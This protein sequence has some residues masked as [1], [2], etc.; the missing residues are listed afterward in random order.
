PE[1]DL[2]VVNG[3]AVDFDYAIAS[4]ADIELYPVGTTSTDFKEKR[5]QVSIDRA[6]VADGHLG[7]LTRNLRLLGFD[8]AYDPRAEDPQLLRVMERENRAL[9]TRDRRLLMHAMVKTGYFPR[10][11]N[12]DQQTIEVIRRFDLLRAIAPFTRCL[13]CN[14]PLQEVAKDD[15][16]EKLEPLTKIYYERFRRCTGCGH[17]YWAGSHFSK[18]QKRLDEIRSKCSTRAA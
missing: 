16:I 5:L 14:A 12:A 4:D 3:Q 15:V 8:V 9:L 13:R 2:I 7:R 11:Q 17:I 6:F 18:L 10:S 1:I